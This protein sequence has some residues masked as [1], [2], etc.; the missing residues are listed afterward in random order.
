MIRMIRNLQLNKIFWSIP[1]ASAFLA[2]LAGV[3][4]RDIYSN[5]FP[6]NFLPG[7]FPQ[8]ALTLFVSLVLFVLIAVTKHHD[9]KMHVIIIGLLGSLFYL[10]SIFT[11]EGI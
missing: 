9:V 1:T 3:L 2:A 7:A 11:M 6:K 5:H 10:Y 4:F 8:D